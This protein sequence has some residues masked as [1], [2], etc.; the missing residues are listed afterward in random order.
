MIVFGSYV[1]CIKCYIIFRLR[2][3]VVWFAASVLSGLPLSGDVLPQNAVISPFVGAVPFAACGLFGLPFGLSLTVA[4]SPI[5]AACL[6]SVAENA[7]QGLAFPAPLWY[8]N[9]DTTILLLYILTNQEGAFLCYYRRGCVPS[10]SF[11]AKIAFFEVFGADFAEIPQNRVFICI[12][13]AL[14]SIFETFCFK[15]AINQRFFQN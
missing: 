15:F 3:F 9:L 14:F 7:E 11:S 10:L 1:F 13:G 4:G 2:W 5:R 12:I 6:V 8:N